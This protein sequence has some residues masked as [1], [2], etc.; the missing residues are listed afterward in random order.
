MLRSDP[1]RLHLPA[2]L[3]CHLKL[4][5]SVSD[6]VVSVKQFLLEIIERSGKINVYFMRV[7]ETSGFLPERYN[8]IRADLLELLTVGRSVYTQ[9]PSLKTGII[10][11]FMV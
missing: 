5:R 8:V 7:H 9:T 4:L 11:S 1:A 6:P 2:L 10:S 3:S